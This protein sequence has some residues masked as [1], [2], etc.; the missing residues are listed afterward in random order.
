MLTPGHENMG[1]A[2]QF[3]LANIANITAFPEISESGI[4]DD[5]AITFAAGTNWTDP[6][7]VTN[8]A[9]FS[10]E[11]DDTD[12]GFLHPA[13]FSALIPKYNSATYINLIFSN[14]AIARITFANGDKIIMG[15]PSHPLKPAYKATTGLQ[16]PDM[17]HQILTFSHS[18]PFPCPFCNS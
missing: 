12:Q 10:N 18:A 14:Y 7:Q 3:E 17:N 4:I 11:S 1:G 16:A 2:V 5:T 8:N 15:A 9:E 6:I 13:V